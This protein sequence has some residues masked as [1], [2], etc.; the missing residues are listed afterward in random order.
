[1]MN[2]VLYGYSTVL[3]T[4]RLALSHLF[5]DNLSVVMNDRGGWNRCSNRYE[6][7]RV[8]S[9]KIERQYATDKQMCIDRELP[10]KFRLTRVFSA[11]F[12][13]LEH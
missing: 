9:S 4:R 8:E 7:S 2:R 10:N 6:S 12:R 5:R 3:T 11:D 1:M 13:K